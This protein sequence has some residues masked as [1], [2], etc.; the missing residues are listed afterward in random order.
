MSALVTH[1]W[2]VELAPTAWMGLRVAVYQDS[3]VNGVKQVSVWVPEIL[4]RR[5]THYIQTE[6]CKVCSTLREEQLCVRICQG[7]H[8]EY[9]ETGILLY[10]MGN[11][12]GLEKWPK[13]NH[14]QKKKEREQKKLSLFTSSTLNYSQF[15]GH[16]RCYFFFHFES[17]IDECASNP[18]LNDGTCTDRVNSFT[19]GC[20]LG[21]RGTRCQTG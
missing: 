20:V 17:D 2:T 5:C 15:W 6:Q 7:I 11:G 3:G 19:C 12:T 8:R 18:C 1:V 16:L 4:L 14:S 9:C 10:V 13:R 21:F